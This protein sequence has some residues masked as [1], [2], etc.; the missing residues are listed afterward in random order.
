V[1]QAYEGASPYSQPPTGDVP[2]QGVPAVGGVA[3]QTACVAGQETWFP[4][5]Q[6]TT[7]TITTRNPQ[8]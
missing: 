6:P 4:P 5:L 3:G 7:P 2:T 8:R 1:S